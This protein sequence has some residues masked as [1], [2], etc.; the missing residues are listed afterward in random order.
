MQDIFAVQERKDLI[1]CFAA[2]DLPWHRI[3]MAEHDV[4]I[5]LSQRR[6]LSAIRQDIPDQIM[7]V[8][9]VRFLRGSLGITIEDI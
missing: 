7:I 3:D 6:K 4:Q 2:E 9:N 5:M 1:R 8:L